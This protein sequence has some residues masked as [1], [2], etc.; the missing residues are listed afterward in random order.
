MGKKYTQANRPLAVKVQGLDADALL[1]VGFR[2]EEGLSSLFRFQL[3]LLVENPTRIAF[4]DLLGKSVT[5]ELELPGGKQPREKK[6]YFNGICRRVAQGERDDRFT[7]F[8]MELVP[9]AWLLTRVTR[10]RVFQDI[11]VPLL[12][13]F[14]LTSRNLD[15]GIKTD[16]RL[17]VNAWEG[18]QYVVQYRETDFNFASRLMAEEGI[19]YYFR[20][21]DGAH[22]MVVGS[23]P[24]DHDSLS[25]ADPVAYRTGRGRV[26][27]STETYD[28]GVIRSWEKAQELRAGKV[29]LHDHT[30]EKPEADLEASRQVQSEVLAGEVTHKLNGFNTP[31]ELYDFPGQYAKRFDGIDRGGGEQPAEIPKISTDKDRT[32]RLRMEQEATATVA[33]HGDSDCRHCVSGHLFTLWAGRGTDEEQARAEGHYILTGVQHAFRHSGGFASGDGKGFSYRNSFTCVPAALPFRPLRTVPKPVIGG[34]Q[35][36]VVVGPKEGEVFTDKYGRVKV[37]F[38]WDRRGKKD[39]DSSCWVRVAQVWASKRWGAHFWP[40]V[41]QEVVVVFEEGDPDQPLI[42]GSVSNAENMPPY[43]MSKNQTRSGIKTQSTPQGKPENFNEIRFEDKKGHEELYVQAE[44]ALNVL[45]KGDENRWVG[46]KS[47]TSVQGDLDIGSEKETVYLGAE[48]AAR[49]CTHGDLQACGVKKSVL[50]SPGY[51]SLIA[52]PRFAERDGRFQVDPKPGQ[53]SWVIVH[54]QGVLLQT[55][56]VQSFVRVYKDQ[57]CLQCGSETIILNASGEILINGTSVK[58][59][60]TGAAPTAPADAPG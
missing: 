1:L 43:E 11:N 29:T 27:K 22:I 41:G 37:Q 32:A 47:K 17:D 40:R 15:L 16:F 36:A 26:V 56:E 13:M 30:F 19:F 48:K 6:R 57:I 4:H 49:I 44:R 52:A 8:R 33:I 25:P 35:T 18:R 23:R 31:L 45:V 3:D 9:S 38:F 53:S 54:N 58:I 59:N 10:R 24:G 51:V 5:V 7:Q 50:A 60:P 20:H 28:G 14:L 2:G 55:P 21:E 46:G 39:P 42:V 12:L 34:T